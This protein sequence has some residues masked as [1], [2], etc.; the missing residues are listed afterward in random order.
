MITHIL[1]DGAFYHDIKKKTSYLLQNIRYTDRYWLLRQYCT[2]KAV[3]LHLFSLT[4]LLLK[5]S[6]IY[7]LLPS[8]AHRNEKF[9]GLTFS[10]SVHNVMSPKSEPFQATDGKWGWHSKNDN[11]MTGCMY[12]QGSHSL[13]SL[14]S[15]NAFYIRHCSKGKTL[16][17]A[18]LVLLSACLHKIIIKREKSAGIHRLL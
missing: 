8:P 10:T 16:G 13:S 4:P 11:S 3:L 14:R 1:K 18:W 6:H 7:V 17:K 5:A 9:K 12:L 2:F 15:L